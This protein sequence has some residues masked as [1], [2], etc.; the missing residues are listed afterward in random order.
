MSLDLRHY[1]QLGA[2]IRL[3]QLEIERK[4]I[5]AAFPE[6]GRGTSAHRAEPPR[7]RRKMSAEARAKIAAAAKRRWAEWR[8][9]K[10]A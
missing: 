7:K 2:A 10:Q 3:Q 9:K 8:K 5:L 4:N 1:V 6:L